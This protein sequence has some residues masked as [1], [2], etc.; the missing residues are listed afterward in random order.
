MNA[1]YRLKDE[2]RGLLEPVY[3]TKVSPVASPDMNVRRGNGATNDRTIGKIR[4]VES[5][6]SG[7]SD[8]A[9]R[10]FF[11]LLC[12]GHLLSETPR[13]QG[14]WMNFGFW[15]TSAPGAEVS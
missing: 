2:S 8:I 14:A 15:Q 1:V 4:D 10:F 7:P 3:I 12:C 13:G 6:K 9:C 11:A 5:P